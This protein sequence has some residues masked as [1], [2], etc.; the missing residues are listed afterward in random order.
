MTFSKDLILELKQEVKNKEEQRTAILEQLTIVDAYID[1]IDDLISKIDFDIPPL[2]NEINNAIRNVE[3][4]YSNRIAIGCSSDLVWE[5][6]TN[7]YNFYGLSFENY[8][9]WEVKKDSTTRQSLPLYGLK[10][11]RKPLD[12]DYGTNVIKEFTG[13][14]YTSTNILTVTSIGGTENIN[15]GDV[16]TDDLVSPSAFTVGNLPTVIGFGTTNVASYN[17]TITGSISTGSTIFSHTGIGTTGDVSV[18]NIFYSDGVTNLNTTVVGFGTTL[19]SIPVIDFTL[20]PPAEVIKNIVTS[21]IILSN[22]AIGIAT[23]KVF[24]VGIVT[25]YS[26]LFLST[27]S[28]QSLNNNIFTAFR[29]TSNIENDFDFEKSPLDPVTIGLITSDTLGLGHKVQ[30]VNNGESNNSALWGEVQGNPEPPVGAGSL[31][32]YKGSSF[33][34]VIASC[35]GAV[36][37]FICT[38]TYVSEGTVSIANTTTAIGVTTIS[39]TGLISTGSTCV[40]Y[41]ASITSAENQLAIITNTNLPKAQNLSQTSATLRRMRDDKQIYAWSLLQSSSYLQSEINRLGN[42]INSLLNTNFTPFETS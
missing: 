13:D 31:T 21:T 18:G 28:N 6:D 39:P 3:V 27:S 25:T 29:V 11:Y 30:I 2:L 7:N 16:I 37:P 40:A 15:I 20:T 22:P 1:K 34:P 42:E 24:N 17:K 23:N 38:N 32:F 8:R 12:R 10:Y 14:I 4:A 35:T 5:E 36:P 33:W 9:F 41:A 26:S 19:S